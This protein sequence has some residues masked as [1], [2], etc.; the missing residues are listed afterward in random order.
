M[1]TQSEKENK[2]F[3]QK[4]KEMTRKEKLKKFG[5]LFIFGICILGLAFQTYELSAQYFGGQTIFS[6]RAVK[7]R[8]SRLPAITIC[9]PIFASMEKLAKFYP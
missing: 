2:S 3:T 4:Y 6:I 7:F 9:Y 8:F 1:G 5:K